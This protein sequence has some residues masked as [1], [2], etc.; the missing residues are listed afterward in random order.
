MIGAREDNFHSW[1]AIPTPPSVPRSQRIKALADR[2]LAQFTSHADCAI[3]NDP[4]SKVLLKRVEVAYKEE[5]SPLNEK[6]T[7]NHLTTAINQ[8]KSSAKLL[9]R[10]HVNMLRNLG[11]TNSPHLLYM[12][13]GLLTNGSC[14]YDWKMARVISLLNKHKDKLDFDSYRPISITSFLWKCYE[15][16]LKAQLTWHLDYYNLLP[17]SQAGFRKGCSTQDHI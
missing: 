8:S 15:S 4:V 5:R 11:A 7:Q 12:F 2:F 16:I 9:D 14:T 17:T 10:I 13:N 3:P 1:A 6:F